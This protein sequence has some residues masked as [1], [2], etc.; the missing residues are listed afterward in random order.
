MSYQDELAHE[1]T[2]LFQQVEDRDELEKK[3]L[4]MLQLKAKESFTNGLKT[5]RAKGKNYKGQ[6][7]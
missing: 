4:A 3:V 7:A 6:T 1:V 5:A 2:Q